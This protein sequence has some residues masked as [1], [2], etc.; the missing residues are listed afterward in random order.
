MLLTIDIPN[1]TVEL[2]G[3]YKIRLETDI[4]VLNCELRDLEF[5]HAIRKMIAAYGSGKSPRFVG[6]H[7]GE[8]QVTWS[9][10]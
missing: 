1:R 5:M 7:L 4:D 6:R 3:G 2:R 8:F 10:E 9:A